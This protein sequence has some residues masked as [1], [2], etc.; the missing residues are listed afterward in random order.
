MKKMIPIV[1]ILFLSG[2]CFRIA[3]AADSLPAAPPS[4]SPQ[5]I[6]IDVSAGRYIIQDYAPATQALAHLPAHFSA[7]A[8]IDEVRRS[9][10]WPANVAFWICDSATVDCVRMAIMDEPGEPTYFFSAV[11]IH[12][13]SSSRKPVRLAGR[14]TFIPVGSALP[15]EI[16]VPSKSEAVFHLKSMVDW[17]QD[18]PLDFEPRLLLVQGVGVK[19]TV[20][21]EKAMPRVS[22]LLPL[23]QTREAFG[24]QVYEDA[25]CD[26]ADCARM[27]SP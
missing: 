23:L 26:R 10:L 24:D 2:L 19:A 25:D 3:F 16:D 8:Q 22:S 9:L 6:Q 18:I 27:D 21:F 12:I 17:K 11:R 15:V 1:G 14:L 7:T 5:L 4:S 20:K 13:G